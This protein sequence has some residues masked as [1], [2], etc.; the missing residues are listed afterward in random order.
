MAGFTSPKGKT[1]NAMAPPWFPQ[2]NAASS[3]SSQGSS[4]LLADSTPLE[5]ITNDLQDLVIRD[6]D[7]T[8]PPRRGGHST[9]PS[10][11]N[12]RG[13]RTS[14]M[15]SGR[16][17]HQ[18]Y[19]PYRAQTAADNVLSPK[20]NN[21]YKLDTWA[22]PQAMAAREYLAIRNSVKRNFKKSFIAKWTIA[23]YMAHRD[24]MIASKNKLTEHADSIDDD[25]HP[26][27]A[28]LGPEMQ[29]ILQ[30]SGLYHNANQTGNY[31]LVLGERTIWCKDWQNGKEE[32]APWP[33]PE[34]MKWEGDDRAKTN[35]GRYLPLPREQDWTIYTRLDKVQNSWSTLQVVEQY[36]LDQV[37]RIPSLEDVYY[38]VDE[39]DDSVKYDL[40]TK[41]LLDAMDAY[42]ES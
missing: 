25:P 26:R 35:V 10:H 6:G 5:S 13:P 31:S 24:M 32:I 42:L 38:P 1:I 12:H 36:P 37:A 30:L 21:L 20:G 9:D 34:E 41:D 8:R 16:P 7:R 4:A 39:I 19:D 40:L 2:A 17:I 14:S 22:S 29:A 28:S 15:D 33:S 23:D 11:R 27:P 18:Q 3:H